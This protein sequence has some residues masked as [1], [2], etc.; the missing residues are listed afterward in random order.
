VVIAKRELYFLITV[1]VL[2]LGWILDYYVIEPYTATAADMATQ[3]DKLNND[4]RDDLRMFDEYKKL[5]AVIQSMK[6]HGLQDDQAMVE[7]Q[8][9]DAIV[10][11]SDW[12]DGLD[13][14]NSRNGRP[15][16]DGNFII[17]NYDITVEGNMSQLSKLLWALEKS[18]IPLRISELTIAPAHEGVDDLNARL[19]VSALCEAREQPAP[20]TP[21]APAARPTEGTGL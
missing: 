3:R 9:M 18:P 17:I 8:T 16:K 11:W 6:D 5:K 4:R 21:E 15:T 2:G 1:I 7:A 10:A 12:A 14:K 20:A 19:Q 13:V